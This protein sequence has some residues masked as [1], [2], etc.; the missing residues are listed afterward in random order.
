MD[1]MAIYQI[2]GDKEDLVEIKSTTFGQEGVLERSDL[3]RLL[4]NRP[5]VLEEGLLII[6]GRIQQLGGL[7]P[8]DRHARPRLGW[9]FGCH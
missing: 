7:Q 4:R 9:P 3:Q 5:E 2:V 6:C 8:Q 1:A